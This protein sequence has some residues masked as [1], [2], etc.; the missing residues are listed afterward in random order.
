MLKRKMM[1]EFL[2]TFA[3][4]FIGCGAA[5]MQAM[6]GSLGHGGV[7]A[8]F[9]LVIMVM[10]YATGHI[11]G[12]HFNPA[13]S[14]AFASIGRFKASELV[15]YIMAQVGGALIA[16]ALLWGTLGPVGELGATV[17]Q[18]T[19]ITGILVEFILSFFLMFVIT[20]VAT[21]S[22]AEGAMAGLAIG[23]T[24]TMAALFGGPLTGASMN[25]ARSL[26]PAVIS[27]QF[28]DLWLYLSVPFLGAVAGAVTYR[29]TRAC[30][31]DPSAPDGAGC[32]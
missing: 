18:T 17:L 32:C 30:P 13:V 16:A 5:M 20:A 31:D 4:V 9:G 28:S 10:I 23:G 11:S 29:W 8:A 3:L 22:R 21:D 2:G 26:G 12:A 14:V 6:T 1:A 19:V 27:G 24:V 25:P 15:P 7:C